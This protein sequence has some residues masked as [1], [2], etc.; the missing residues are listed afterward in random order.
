MGKM[1]RDR[2][3]RTI[4]IGNDRR[5]SP[6]EAKYRPTRTGK[7]QSFGFAVPPG[8]LKDPTCARSGFSAIDAY[9]APTRRSNDVAS[10]TAMGHMRSLV[11][12]GD[13]N[14]FLGI[15]AH[16]GVVALN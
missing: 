8:V 10:M 14:M 6:T 7:A 2:I 12:R 16:V 5:I 4:Q 11:G 1:T 15:F 9:F 3:T 13:Q